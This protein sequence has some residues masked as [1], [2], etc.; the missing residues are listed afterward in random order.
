[1]SKKKDI[2]KTDIQTPDG[3]AIDWIH[4]LLYWTDTGFNSIQVASLDGIKKAT[5]IS[6]DLDEPRGITL[7]PKNGYV[8]VF[9]RVLYIPIIVPILLSDFLYY[10]ERSL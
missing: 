6:H 5:I 10:S 7:D 1:M 9:I 3:I 8:D 4:D 2:I